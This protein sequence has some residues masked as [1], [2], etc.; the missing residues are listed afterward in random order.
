MSEEYESGLVSV[1]I[2]L[3]NKQHHIARAIKSVLGQT[4]QD[5][6]LIVVDDGSTDGSAEV[7]KTFND[8]RIRL[9]HREH[10]NS[11]GGH[12]A[13]N[14]GIAE[15]HADLIAF[16]DADD[17]WMPEHLITIKQLS[18]KFPECG[19]YATGVTYH[20]EDGSEFVSKYYGIP[21]APWEG[22]V[23]NYF[24][25]ALW[26]SPVCSSTVAIWKSTFDQVGVFPVGEHHGGDLDMWCRIVLKY[27]FAL[28]TYLG[29][30]SYRDAD[31]RVSGNV[32]TDMYTCLIRTLDS[33][34]KDKCLPDWV[35]LND[36]REYR[37]RRAITSAKSKVN[38]GG[39]NALLNE[40]FLSARLPLN[41]RSHLIKWYILSKMPNGILILL[42]KIK[43]QFRHI[44]TNR[45]KKCVE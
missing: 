15:A 7:V 33:A 32:T 34:L 18:E 21:E 2:P 22:I 26:T 5:F 27:R 28:R 40:I 41:L 11:W 10:I 1:V 38:L 3:Y 36:M 19:A 9:I 8:P 29:A 16:L 42:R 39:V 24:Q 44:F 17:E 12:A 30:V 31:N 14:R 6:E 37:N 23:P 43:F 35:S 25:L 13:R 4:Y 20:N 45:S